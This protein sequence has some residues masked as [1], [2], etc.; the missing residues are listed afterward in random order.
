MGDN[1][2]SI[3]GLT[4]HD[5]PYVP[6]DVDGCRWVLTGITGWF[7]S[8]GP[9]SEPLERPGADGDYDGE[10]TLDA[11]TVTVE[12]AIV[13]P[14]RV[15]L[16]VAMDRVA[17]VLTGS[18]RYDTLT[19]DESARGLSRQASVRLG[20][21]TLVARTGPVSASLSLSLFAPDPRRYS[22]ELHSET[23]SRFQPGGGFTFPASFPIS[24]GANGSD[25]TA[26]V[27]NAGTTATWPVLRFTGPTTNPY[28]T[29]VGGGTVAAA[30]TL[31][32]GQ[33]LVVDCGLRSV[34]LGSASR[35]QF[36]TSDDFFA[37]PPG[38]SEIYFSADDGAGQLTVEWRDAW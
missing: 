10:P 37:I 1:A 12:G 4:L 30:I 7:D 29:L 27:S 3:G 8:P 22:S 36:L 34:L 14:D 26:S 15:S 32:A 13:A 25:G 28:A 23:V 21:Q 35:R 20:G 18:Q 33:E 2:V 9:R 16:Q 31:A 5:G 17:A 19:V 24:F 38:T 6:Y 11:R